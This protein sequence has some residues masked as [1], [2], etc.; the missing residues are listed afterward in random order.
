MKD[1]FDTIVQNEVETLNR[2]RKPR[3]G[4]KIARYQLAQSL[5]SD[6]LERLYGEDSSWV[7]VDDL[8]AFVASERFSIDDL[9]FS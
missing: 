9:E 1:L 8:E 6:N 2:K 7:D 5:G 4:S 3:K